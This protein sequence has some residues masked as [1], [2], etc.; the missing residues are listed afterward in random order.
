MK[1]VHNIIKIKK[2]SN[3]QRQLIFNHKII[4]AENAINI[5]YWKKAIKIAKE[6]VI[7]GMINFI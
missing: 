5:K 7:A 2:K 6:Y 1:I 3:Y 4:Y